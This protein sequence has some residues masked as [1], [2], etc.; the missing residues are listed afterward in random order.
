MS[1]KH[2]LFFLI[3]HTYYL[4]LKR[5][6]DV[7]GFKIARSSII[8]SLKKI[9]GN[10]DIAKFYEFLSCFFSDLLVIQID[11]EIDNHEYIITPCF[12][13]KKS[14]NQFS[15]Y[16]ILKIDQEKVLIF[17]NEKKDYT[18]S[19]N[20]FQNLLKGSIII[21]KEEDSYNPSE[22]ILK[23][24]NKEQ[25]ADKDYKENIKIIDSFI[26]KKECKKII[27]FCEDG[28]LFQQSK[29]NSG[30]GTEVSDYR[31]SSSA[32]IEEKG[33]IKPIIL[34]L[35]EKI[36]ILLSC[37]IHKIEKLQCVRY[38]KD[39]IFKPHFDTSTKRK[40]TCLL[41][42]NEGFVGGDTY[43]PEI[44]LGV[45]PKV[46]KLLIFQNLNEDNNVIPQAL[47]QGS[48]IEDGVKYACNIWVRN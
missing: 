8:D 10:F 35:K 9:E 29:I 14:D 32:V 25:N 47:H 19:T 6:I 40:S 12:L 23:E 48:P 45:T 3:S 42:L 28:N 31:I 37:D 13:L 7:S 44:D 33:E 16:V 11:S 2:S 18:I 38:Y 26:S 20:E 24:Y 21:F 39:E 36:A 5:F 4:T 22:K 41:Y 27:D 15:V 46:G 34:S 17:E 30:S 43:F 1:S